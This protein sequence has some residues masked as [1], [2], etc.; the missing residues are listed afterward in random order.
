MFELNEETVSSCSLP[1]F[2]FYIQRSVD[3]FNEDSYFNAD[4]CHLTLLVI[5]IYQYFSPM[6]LFWSGAT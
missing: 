1:V 2:F 6:L 4:F 5:S 3:D